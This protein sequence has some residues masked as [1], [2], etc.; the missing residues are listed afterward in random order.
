MK[1]EQAIALYFMQLMLC[2]FRHHALN[3]ILNVKELKNHSKC[4]CYFFRSSG[5][6]ESYKSRRLPLQQGHLYLCLC[7]GRVLSNFLNVG[8]LSV[9]AVLRFE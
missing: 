7:K 2:E 8:G 4:R 6:R 1:Y 9:S 3:D 5:S